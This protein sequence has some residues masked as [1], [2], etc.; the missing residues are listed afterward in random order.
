M[1]FFDAFKKLNLKNSSYKQAVELYVMEAYLDD[2]GKGDITTKYFVPKKRKKV[3]AEIVTN[4]SGI[5]AGI[6]EAEWFLK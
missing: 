4:E 3:I 6:Q 1:I 5:L 2:V